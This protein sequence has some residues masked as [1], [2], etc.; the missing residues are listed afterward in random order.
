MSV[1]RRDFLIGTVGVTAASG[2]L[3]GCESESDAGMQLPNVRELAVD[4]TLFA[5]GVASGDPLSDRVILWTRVTTDSVEAVSVSYVVAKDPE[6]TEV[7]VEGEA[8]AEP[9]V[10]FTVKVDV[11]GLSAGTTYYYAFVHAGERRSTI[12]RTRTLPEP[13]AEHVRLAFSSC[14]NYSYGWFHAY[15]EIAERTDLDVWVHLGD[16]IYEYDD[17]TYSDL[18]IERR[19]DPPTETLTLEDYR[20]RYAHYRKD[21][22]LQEIHRQHPLIVVWDDHEVANNAYKEGAE[23]HTEDEGDYQTRKLAGTQAFVEWLP[24]RVPQPKGEVPKIYR[25]FAFG[26]L[27]D[28]IMLDTRLIGRDLQAGTDNEG[29]KGDASIWDAPGREVIGSV[30]EKW[31]TDR[32]SESKARGASWRLIGNQVIFSPGRDPRDGTILFADFWDGYRPARDRIADFITG[33]GID[34]V[35]FLTGDIHTSWAMDV[36]R[37]PFDAEQYDPQTGEGSYAVEI[38]GPSITSEGLENNELKDAAPQLLRMGNPHL[39]L[40]EVTRKGYVLVDVTPERVQ[41]DWYYVKNI[42][43]PER[44]GQELGYSCTCA[45]GTAHLVEAPAATPTRDDAPAA[46]PAEA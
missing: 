46:A 13:G 26:D 29:D 10:D 30:Q 11:E 8:Q 39:K 22:D 1:T 5:H 41:A 40:S 2:A 44:Q 16:Y 23:N 43:S 33:E 3:V 17:E 19:L 6:L 24:I 20:R 38:V 7:V 18:T 4:T 32:L 28:L 21:P 45:S 36:A 9:A 14:S 42:K 34:N 12:G 27:F 25:S 31:L 15:R 35:V 37:D